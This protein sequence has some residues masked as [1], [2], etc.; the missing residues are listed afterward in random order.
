MPARAYVFK[1]VSQI[2]SSH[3]Y[4]NPTNIYRFIEHW[5]PFADCSVFMLAI[6][7]EVGYTIP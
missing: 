1:L 4:I 5:A 3:K 6:K 2:Y 7:F